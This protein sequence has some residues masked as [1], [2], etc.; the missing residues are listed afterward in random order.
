GPVG[1]RVA[2]GGR[3][4]RRRRAGGLAGTSLGAGRGGGRLVRIVLA[5]TYVPFREGGG[6]R[7]VES[8]RR[9]LA[10]RGFETEVALIPFDPAWRAVP[11]QTLALRLL[12]L[13]EASGD[14]IDRLI[15]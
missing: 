9:E 8:L 1:R 7:L 12:D 15:T 10:A 3:R 5:S 14:R 11:E 6:T 13:S 4:A 2:A